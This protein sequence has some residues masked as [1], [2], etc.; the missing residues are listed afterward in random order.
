MNAA[1]AETGGGSGSAAF[2]IRV[3]TARIHKQHIPA[4]QRRLR[5]VFMTGACVPFV[6]GIIAPHR[7]QDDVGVQRV[8]LL[9]TAIRPQ[10]AAQGGGEGL[11]GVAESLKGGSFPVMRIRFRV[12]LPADADAAEAVDDFAVRADFL[13]SSFQLLPHDGFSVYAGCHLKPAFFIQF[14]GSTKIVNGADEIFMH[15]GFY[16]IKAFFGSI[17]TDAL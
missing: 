13:S 10:V 2:G 1:A 15:I 5:G 6:G 3:G 12:F 9:R 11:S 17:R 7:P 8:H 16:I 4:A 14:S